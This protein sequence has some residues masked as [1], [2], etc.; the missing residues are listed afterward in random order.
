HR[1]L[2]AVILIVC[3]GRLTQQVGPLFGKFSR[4]LVHCLGIAL[5]ASAL[6]LLLQRL[7]DLVLQFVQG[8]DPPVTQAAHESFSFGVSAAVIAARRWR[9][10]VGRCA[11][12]LSMAS[13]RSTRS[14]AA[15]SAAT[16]T[17]ES[18]ASACAT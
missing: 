5:R 3:P 2:L 1:P 16:R 9:T 4:R 17:V 13:I 10:M 6:V 8:I 7:L 15:V 18:A 11:I 12:S 14:S